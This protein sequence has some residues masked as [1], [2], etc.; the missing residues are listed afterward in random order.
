ML[1]QQHSA[2]AVPGVSEVIVPTWEHA[3]LELVL[4][5]L[6]HL[7]HQAGERWLTWIAP[8]LPPKSEL[9][10]YGFNPR[11]LRFIRSSGDEQSLWMMW[12]AL[13]NGTSAFVV[14][15]FAKSYGLVQTKERKHLQQACSQGNSRALVL[16]LPGSELVH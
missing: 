5:M 12:D 1:A 8:D 11:T 2:L 7:S 10:K 15:S 13:N 4:P 14:S 16:T 3:S 9:D 6:A